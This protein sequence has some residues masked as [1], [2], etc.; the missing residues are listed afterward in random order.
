MSDFNGQVAIVTGAASGLGL[1]IAKKLHAEGAAV[2]LLDLNDAAL[3]TAAKEVGSNAVAFAVDL[4]KQEQ[5]ESVVR[6][7]AERFGR[8]DVL[9]NSAGVTG[10]TNIKSHEVDTCQPAFRFRC[11]FHG[12][13][14]YLARRVAVHAETKLR[15]HPA[16]RLGSR[17]RRQRGHAGL[18]SIEGCCDRNDQGAGQGIRRDWNY[19]KRAGA[20]SDSDPDG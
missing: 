8:V 17:K 5:V 14:F 10:A 13:V 16:H 20:G 4:T 3:Q 7:I 15:S 19:G 11:E 2:A 1:A 18:L 12:V 9:V 6:Q